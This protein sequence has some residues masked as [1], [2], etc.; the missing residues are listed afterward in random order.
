MPSPE[1]KATPREPRQASEA[2]SLLYMGARTQAA[3]M[4]GYP[5]PPADPLH[6]MTCNFDTR[7]VTGD[8]T[9]RRATGIRARLAALGE[10]AGPLQSWVAHG[11]RHGVRFPGFVHRRPT[12]AASQGPGHFSDPRARGSEARL[13]RHL[14]VAL[15]H[16]VREHD[17]A[18][19]A[20]HGDLVPRRVHEE[21]PTRRKVKCVAR[22]ALEHHLREPLLL[23][24]LQLHHLLH[25]PRQASGRARAAAA[26]AAAALLQQQRARGG[27]RGLGQ[28]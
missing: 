10:L 25:P 12:R 15:R 27:Q 1:R 5:M 23:Q 20:R 26:A 16:Q 28:R 17:G 8:C 6:S 2:V 21:A 13:L 19:P 14:L 18:R 7:L 24:L 9:D 4:G 11:P 3:C 22:L